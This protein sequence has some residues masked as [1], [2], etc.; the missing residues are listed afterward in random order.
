MRTPLRLTI[1][2]IDLVRFQ[3]ILAPTDSPTALE[4][5]HAR[6]LSTLPDRSGS[7]LR[8]VRPS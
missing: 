7:G 2:A 4:G 8:F 1:A 5:T 3:W 6:C